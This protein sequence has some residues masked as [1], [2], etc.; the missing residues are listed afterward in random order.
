MLLGLTPPLPA[1]FLVA[2][3]VLDLAMWPRMAVFLFPSAGVT[4]M[5]SHT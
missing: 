4:S 1:G 5:H 2:Q 3:A